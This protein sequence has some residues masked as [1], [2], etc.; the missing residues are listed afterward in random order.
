MNTPTPTVNKKRK[1]GAICTSDTPAKQEHH[2]RPHGSNKTFSTAAAI[3]EYVAKKQEKQ[4]QKQKDKTSAK[5]PQSATR[6]KPPSPMSPSQMK[7]KPLPRQRQTLLKVAVQHAT[8]EITA[9]R[10]KLSRNRRVMKTTKRSSTRAYV[11][12]AKEEE[13]VP[14]RGSVDQEYLLEEVGGSAKGR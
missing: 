8:Q 4:A 6:S 12:E 5:V 11:E 10:V 3:L 13:D 1:A 9:K 14:N 7:L 2:P